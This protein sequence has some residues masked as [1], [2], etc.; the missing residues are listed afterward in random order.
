VKRVAIVCTPI[1]GR[2]SDRAH[3]QPD[4]A[5]TRAV[6]EQT[7]PS[8][9]LSMA[10]FPAMAGGSTVSAR[11]NGDALR[12]PGLLIKGLFLIKTKQHKTKRSVSCEAAVVVTSESPIVVLVD[13][14]VV[15]CIEA[16]ISQQ[17]GALLCIQAIDEKVR[18]FIMAL[19]TQRG[20]SASDWCSSLYT[21]PL[22]LLTFTCMG[23]HC[24]LCTQILLLPPVFHWWHDGSFSLS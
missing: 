2:T 22:V 14:M 12:L 16:C 21:L 4:I 3:V 1:L 8:I 9:R 17:C 5:G 15:L 20:D 7:F 24:P 10:G 13:L 23:A 19:S 6:R 11:A 18:P